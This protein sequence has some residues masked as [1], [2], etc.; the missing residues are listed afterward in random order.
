MAAAIHIPLEELSA[1]TRALL[2]QAKECG[3]VFIDGHGI[4]FKIS[5]MPGRTAAEALDLL[6]N[7]A[8]ADVEVDD[9]WSNDM[10]EI[11]ALR[12]TEPYRDSWE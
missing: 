5:R 2:E 9:E 4:H 12:H 11:I 6:R 1:D 3:E 8:D 7:S 10:R